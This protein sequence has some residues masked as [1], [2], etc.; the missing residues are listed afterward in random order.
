M[1][2]KQA[3]KLNGKPKKGIH[4][5]KSIMQSM[6]CNIRYA[7]SDNKTINIKQYETAAKEENSCFK[8]VVLR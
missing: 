8:D 3:M 4:G 7:A 5:Y 2:A 1:L 6:S